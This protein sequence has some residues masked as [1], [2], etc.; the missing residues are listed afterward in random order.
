MGLTVK[1]ISVDDVDSNIKSL[2]EKMNVLG[3]EVYVDTNCVQIY[4]KNGLKTHEYEFIDT[5]I[6]DFTDLLSGIHCEE[7][8]LTDLVT[9]NVRCMDS[10]MSYC[11][12][13]RVIGFEKLNTKNVTSMYGMFF[14]SKLGSIDLSAFD[15]SSC[16]NFEKMF[17]NTEIK[18]LD[19]S[20]FD[21]S[22]AINAG[23]MFLGITTDELIV[24]LCNIGSEARAKNDYCAMTNILNGSNIGTIPKLDLTYL[25]FNENLNIGNML[26]RTIIGEL[27]IPANNSSAKMLLKTEF[28]TSPKVVVDASQEISITCP[29]CYGTI[30]S[31]IEGK[32]LRLS[33]N[34]CSLTATFDMA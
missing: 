22:K 1:I 27:L 14:A 26:H 19:T 20:K 16:H 8:D 29:K 12:I 23:K 7:L 25:N 5:E 28:K 17:S 15:T 21:M 33:C 9:D 34:C 31:H 2:V 11:I 18:R 24:D 32:K 13:D 6:E 30:T 4:D 10:F 3:V